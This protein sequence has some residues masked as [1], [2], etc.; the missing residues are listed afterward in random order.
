MLDLRGHTDIP[1]PEEVLAE[2]ADACEKSGTEMFVIGA[3]AR[4]LVI[5]ARM[6]TEPVRATRDVDIAVAVR[7]DAQFQELSQ[8]L[9]RTRSAPQ[10]FIVLGIEVDI[11]PFGG[12]E[13]D[14]TVRFADGSRLDVTGIREAH[15]TSVL[16]RLPKGTEVHVASPAA[17]TAL[18]ILAW[19]DRDDDNPKD[20][21][22][23]GG[24][25][26]L[27]SHRCRGLHTAR[28]P[29]RTRYHPRPSTAPHA[30]PTYA[31]PVC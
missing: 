11:I 19:A 30:D 2:L 21:L 6:Q 3:A 31:D 14:R 20:G 7:T 13:S 25:L 27:R 17:L 15:S 8:L 10:K 9:T 22:D 18:K 5:H 12:N 4:D 23:L 26:P 24:Q 28:W 29:G 1:A 16:V